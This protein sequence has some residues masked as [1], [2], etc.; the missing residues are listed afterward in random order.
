MENSD[1]YRSA[2][3]LAVGLCRGGLLMME[4][5]SREGLTIHLRGGDGTIMVTIQTSDCMDD[6]RVS[7][8][9]KQVNLVMTAPDHHSANIKNARKVI[10]TLDVRE[11][12]TQT[13][14]NTSF[15]CKHTLHIV[16]GIYYLSHI[17]F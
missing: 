2:C 11:P 4:T 8:S 6:G 5:C 17:F 13:L 14:P 7:I 12:F 3:E 9:S 15:N 16:Q 10:V 1:T